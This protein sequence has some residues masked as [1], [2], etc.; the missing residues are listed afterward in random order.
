MTATIQPGN[1]VRLLLRAAP[2][3]REERFVVVAVRTYFNRVINA[4]M[5][6]LVAHGLRPVVAPIAAELALDRISA[7][8]T[9]PEFLSRLIDDDCEV[10][11]LVMRAIQLYSV[12]FAGMAS[13]AIAQEVGAHNIDFNTAALIVQ[14][15][16]SYINPAV[17]G[18]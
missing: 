17:L 2:A 1:V 11:E 5:R 14:R 13:E 6:K 15:N 16:L 4:S 12:R 10:A 8:R 3:R 7:A 18:S 9:F